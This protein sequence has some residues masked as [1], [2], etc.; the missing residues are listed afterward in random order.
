MKEF[1]SVVKLEIGGNN[2]EA[3]SKEEYVGLVKEQFMEEY[4]MN[5]MD[6]E[7]TDIKEMTANPFSLYSSV[8][9]WENATL[10][11]EKLI[12]EFGIEYDKIKKE[13]I[14][15][16]IGDTESDGLIVDEIYNRIHS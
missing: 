7:I 11:L 6:E 2:F 10:K 8:D 13:F 9:G 15:V 4:G 1:T 14:D 16:G 3:K 12:E 5:L